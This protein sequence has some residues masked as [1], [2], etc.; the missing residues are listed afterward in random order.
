MP[1]PEARQP[2]AGTAERLRSSLGHQPGVPPL[3]LSALR[4][5]ALA[6][7][8]PRSADDLTAIV[9]IDIA[10]IVAVARLAGA[11]FKKIRQ[12]AVVGEILA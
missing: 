11:L 12:P 3:V 8:N 1:E 7:T 4:F 9:F 6:A 2:R 10:I 5:A